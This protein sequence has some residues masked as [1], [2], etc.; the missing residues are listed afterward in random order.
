[1]AKLCPL[2]AAGAGGMGDGRHRRTPKAKSAPGRDGQLVGQRH[3]Q[4]RHLRC[5]FLPCVGGGA[6]VRQAISGIPWHDRARHVGPM[7]SQ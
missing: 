2:G 6:A 4:R 7:T 3:L 1:M 5:P